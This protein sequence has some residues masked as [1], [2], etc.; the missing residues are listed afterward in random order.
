MKTLDKN[1]LT[2]GLQDFELKKYTLLAYLQEVH[3]SFFDKK[4]YPFLSDL[5]FHYQNLVMLKENK[6]I[7]YDQFPKLISKADFEKLKFNYKEMVEDDELMN[8]LEEIL[9]YSIPLIS[10]SMAE[11]KNIHEYIESKTEFSPVG[12]SPLYPDMGYIFINQEHEKET[13][14]YQY[15]ITVFER[16][17]EK[18]RGIHTSFVEAYTKKLT[19]T[20]EN[21]K[22]DLTRKYKNLPNPA[23]YLVNCKINCPI[24]ETL[25]PIAKRLVVKYVSTIA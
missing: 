3:N 4:L 6:K 19:N 17:E 13:F 22:I 12:I 11:G 20:F 25:L 24:D 18:Y 7:I 16:A 8:F 10:E 5:I 2:T 15:Q 23:T 1:W 14:I 9:T 21:I